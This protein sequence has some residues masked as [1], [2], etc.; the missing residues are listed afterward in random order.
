MEQEATEGTENEE[1]FWQ[2]DL[3]QKERKDFSVVRLCVIL[4]V[5][6]SS[7]SSFS[8]GLT[9][10]VDWIAFWSREL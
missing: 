1:T 2:K 9:A 3:R 7:R 4:S 6:V 8:C 5:S 10:A